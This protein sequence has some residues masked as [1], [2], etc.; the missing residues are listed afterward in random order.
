MVMRVVV[1]G[2]NGVGDIVVEDHLD[3][4]VVVL[5]EL[6]GE[7]RGG[8]A[9]NGAVDADDAPH[10]RSNSAHIVRHHDNSHLLAQALQNLVQLLL[11][12]VIDK[13]GRLVENQQARLIDN[14]PAQQCALQLTTREAADGAT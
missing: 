10:N 1:A 3:R 11:E 8:V 6:G 4:A 9:V 12:A 13:V 7:F 14:R 2:E 5:Q